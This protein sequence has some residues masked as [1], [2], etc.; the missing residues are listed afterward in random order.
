MR[1][2]AATMA[3]ASSSVGTGEIDAIAVFI[4]E[5]PLSVQLCRAMSV[6]VGPKSSIGTQQTKRLQKPNSS[7]CALQHD[8]YQ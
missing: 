8:P 4:D 6:S 2:T 1:V 5:P 3:A 7:Q